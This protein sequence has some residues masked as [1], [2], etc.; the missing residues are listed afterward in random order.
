M[1]KQQYEYL[2]QPEGPLLV[3]TVQEVTDKLIYQYGLFN[4]TRFLAQIISG[5]IAHEKIMHS[6]E[7]FGKEVV[8]AVKEAIK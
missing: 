3:G 7:L 6:I 1:T 8:P 5:D 2:C 4:N